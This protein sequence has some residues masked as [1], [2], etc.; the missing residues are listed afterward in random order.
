MLTLSK[1]L[2]RGEEGHSLTEFRKLSL[3]NVLIP[4]QV[5]EGSSSDDSS[6]D[7]SSG[8]DTSSSDDS[9]S[10]TSSSDDGSSEE[11]GA[12][13]ASASDEAIAEESA[14][15]AES[16]AAQSAADFSARITSYDSVISADGEHPTLAPNPL[17]VPT[18]T[19]GGG[20]VTTGDSGVTDG[21]AV[22]T[23]ESGGTAA[24]T[25]TSFTPTR[26]TGGDIAAATSSTATEG[27]SS[28][29][30]DSS[31]G[32]MALRYGDK[33]SSMCIAGLLVVLIWM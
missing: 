15:A 3:L 24:M 2:S 18:Y 20:A 8:S 21:S 11:A 4:R 9:S 33:I 13:A 12:A 16:A 7:S 22:T 32:V 25:S 28:S 29:S 17:I 5:D 19:Y 30:S 6:N 23:G 27:G 1:L 26:T 31:N 14:A 10:D